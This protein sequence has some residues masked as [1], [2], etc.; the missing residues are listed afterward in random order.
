[1]SEKKARSETDVTQIEKAAETY[2]GMVAHDL[3]TPLSIILTCSEYLLNYSDD[4]LTSE[5]KNFLSRIERNA[6]KS[7]KMVSSLLDITSL[8]GNTTLDRQEVGAKGFIEAIVENLTFLGKEKNI[9]IS[10]EIGE[11]FNLSI[12]RDRMEQVLEN[13]VGNA[14]K[15]TNEHKSIVVKASEVDIDD[16]RFSR[17][18][19]IDQGVGIPEDKLTDLFGKF[20]QLEMGDAKNLGIGLGLSIA[21]E[22]VKAHEGFISVESK[23]GKGS[24][25]QVNLPKTEASEAQGLATILLVDDDSDILELVG[26]DLTEAGFDV[27]YAENGDVALRKLASHAVDMVLSDVQ[28]PGMD[29]FELLSAIKTK[30]SIPIVLASGFY[31]NLSDDVAQSLFKAEYFLEKPYDYSQLFEAVNAV[32]GTKGKESAS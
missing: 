17:I 13:L 31:P 15:F 19:V 23:L 30:W 4:K 5:Q 10:A 21:D 1:M 6:E 3:R 22:F 20:T 32:L 7:I 16:E 26:D 28:M 9:G 14:I 27:I 8:K 25:F 18:E 12:D 11:D 2:V 24:S 29:G